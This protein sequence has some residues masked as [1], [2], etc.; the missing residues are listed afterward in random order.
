MTRRAWT[1]LALLCTLALGYFGGVLHAG[2]AC[3]ALQVRPAP[4]ANPA[5]RC[6]APACVRGPQYREVRS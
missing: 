2:R 1:A 4:M 5:P 6:V 3:K